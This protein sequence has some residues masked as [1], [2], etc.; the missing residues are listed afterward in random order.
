M[1][2]SSDFKFYYNIPVVKSGTGVKTD[3]SQERLGL[4][5]SPTLYVW[6]DVFPP[7]AMWKAKLS[8][9]KE[10]KVKPLIYITH[11]DELKV[12]QKAKLKAT[13]ETPKASSI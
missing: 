9:F 7:R 12:N 2:S 11:K 1:D 6:Q 4:R 8:T 13:T 5:N 10:W 3:R